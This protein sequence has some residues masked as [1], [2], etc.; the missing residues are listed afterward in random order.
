[1][2]GKERRWRGQGTGTLRKGQVEGAEE[3]KRRGGSNQTHPPTHAT[4]GRLG[5]IQVEGVEER[6]RKRWS[7]S[8]TSTNPNHNRKIMEGK[9]RRSRG[10]KEGEVVPIKHIHQPKGS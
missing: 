3:R 10:K 9:G 6:K 5:R 8:N 4:T 1:V 2:K 7:Q